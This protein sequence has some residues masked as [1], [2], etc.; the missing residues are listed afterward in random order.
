MGQ[1]RAAGEARGRRPA[2]LTM[3]TAAHRQEVQDAKAASIRK[4]IAWR[5]DGDPGE[6]DNYIAHLR[7]NGTGENG[8][9][10]DYDGPK[11]L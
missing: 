10:L 3:R 1:S 5:R 2:E 9:P 4:E 8:Y 6:A 11:K 7:R